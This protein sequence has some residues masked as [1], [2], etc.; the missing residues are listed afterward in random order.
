MEQAGKSPET[1]QAYTLPHSTKKT[2]LKKSE[3]TSIGNIEKIPRVRI[4]EFVK[5]ET[6]FAVMQYFVSFKASKSETIKKYEIMYVLGKSLIF[7]ALNKREIN[8][9]KTNADKIK[10]LISNRDGCI[11][12]FNNFKSFKELKHV[13]H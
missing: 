12:E 4:E 1:K 13:E 5:K 6:P 11:W 2:P 8:F 7:K 9:L 3:S 10:L